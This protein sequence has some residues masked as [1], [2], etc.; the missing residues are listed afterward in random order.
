MLSPALT[1]FSLAKAD[2]RI[3]PRLILLAVLLRASLNSSFKL[4]DILQNGVLP[5]ASAPASSVLQIGRFVSWPS[6]AIPYAKTRSPIQCHIS[7]LGVVD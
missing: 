3:L 4:P 7:P 2:P 6:F 1:D 5:D